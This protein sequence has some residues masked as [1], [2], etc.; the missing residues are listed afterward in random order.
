ML[1][2]A[3]CALLNTLLGDNTGHVLPGRGLTDPKPTRG[4]YNRLPH[5]NTAIKMPS[6]KSGVYSMILA[7]GESD[8]K[9][10]SQKN[11]RNQ[12][13]QLVLIGYKREKQS[14][15]HAGRICEQ[16]NTLTCADCRKREP[17]IAHGV[18][19]RPRFLCHSRGHACR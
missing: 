18:T 1:V 14:Q 2:P 6:V 11:K 15:P 17:D 5:S 9:K 12:K 19:D 7:F 13:Y 8:L 16:K 10:K 4:P 3:L